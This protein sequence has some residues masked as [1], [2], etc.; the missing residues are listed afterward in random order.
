MFGEGLYKGQM[1]QHWDTHY[2]LSTTTLHTQVVYIK[3]LQ[4][5]CAVDE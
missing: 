3:S 4:V 1:E 5:G 2:C